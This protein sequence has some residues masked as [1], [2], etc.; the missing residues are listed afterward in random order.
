MSESDQFLRYAEETLL[1]VAQATTDAEKRLLLEL[2]HT[3]TQAA[4]ASAEVG[5]RTP[6]ER[7]AP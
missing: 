7:R 6:P 4:V 2:A 3:W 5:S 1:W